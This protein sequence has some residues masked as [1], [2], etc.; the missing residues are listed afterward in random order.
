MI[1]LGPNGKKPL[2]KLGNILLTCTFITYKLDK[3]KIIVMPGLYYEYFKIMGDNNLDFYEDL[4]IETYKLPM[5]SY[6]DERF[7]DN[8]PHML[9]FPS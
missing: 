2:E 9:D 6:I 4:G 5:D 1:Y 8:L 7:Y 3:D